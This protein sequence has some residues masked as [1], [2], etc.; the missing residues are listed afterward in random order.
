MHENWIKRKV[1]E[2]NARLQTALH[3]LLA[4]W[5]VET[6]ARLREQQTVGRRICQ[7]SGCLG[8]APGSEVDGIEHNTKQVRR[9]E[10]QLRRP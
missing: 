5:P 1:L 10:A 4:I 2:E 7:E 8:L 3:L 9:N 6:D